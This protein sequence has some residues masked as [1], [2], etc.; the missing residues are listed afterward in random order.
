[1]KPLFIPLK[2][3]WFTEFRAG[4]KKTEFRLYGPRWNET[5]IIPGRSVTL[6]HGYSGE[7]IAAR[8]AKLRLIKNKT[9]EGIYPLGA[10]LAAIDLEFL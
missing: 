9:K 8:V 1:V 5:T 3:Q 6:S 4:R 10:T 2:T 7:R